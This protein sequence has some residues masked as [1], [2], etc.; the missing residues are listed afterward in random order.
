MAKFLPI[1]LSVVAAVLVTG[2]SAQLQPES[3]RIGSTSIRIPAPEGF[4][5]AAPQFPRLFERFTKTEPVESS[6]LQVFV[7]DSIMTDLIRNE[8]LDLMFY[9]KVST[10]KQPIELDEKQFAVH[11]KQMESQMS[12]F[13]DPKNPALTEA[14]RNIRKGLREHNGEESGFAIGTSKDLGVFD[15]QPF[16]FSHMVL[17]QVE[18]RK[19][20]VPLLAASSTILINGKIVFVQTYRRLSEVMDAET[21][22]DFSKKWNGEILQANADPGRGSSMTDSNARRLDRVF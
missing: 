20:T 15:R 6:V 8:D 13:F 7:D 19:G 14:S 11:A 9:A 1:A 5:P 22:R 17:L 12:G 2:V 21:L 16:I 3:F 4:A 10:P 18:G